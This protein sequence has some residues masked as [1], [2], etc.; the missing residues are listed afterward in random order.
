MGSKQARGERLGARTEPET[1]IVA[2]PF[3][4]IQIA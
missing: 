3:R 2:G 4:G 1:V